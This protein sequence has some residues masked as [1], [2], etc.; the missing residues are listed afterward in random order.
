MT[1]RVPLTLA[2]SKTPL[3]LRIDLPANFPISKP[4]LVVMSRVVHENIEPVSK[5]IIIPMLEQWDLYKHGSNLLAVCRD[6]HQRFDQNP[7]IPEKFVQLQQN[8]SGQNQP[9]E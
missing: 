4:H 1:Y 8:G 9:N 3:F 7:P 5:S 2:V 6:I